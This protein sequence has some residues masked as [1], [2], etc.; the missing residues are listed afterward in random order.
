[1]QGIFACVIKKIQE[2]LTK[3]NLSEWLTFKVTNERERE[4][5]QEGGQNKLKGKRC[6][7]YQ[8]SFNVTV[9]VVLCFVSNKCEL[10][11][12]I[13]FNIICTIPS[14]IISTGL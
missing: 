10:L 4:S 13:A 8:Y 1:M 12:S 2:N 9:V 3:F 7:G 14:Q 11:N 6:Y 5:L